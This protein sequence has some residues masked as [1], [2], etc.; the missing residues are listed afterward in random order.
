MKVMQQNEKQ[1]YHPLDY[2]SCVQHITKAYEENFYISF[3]EKCVSSI[4][5]NIQDDFIQ[6]GSITYSKLIV[7]HN[8]KKIYWPIQPYRIESDIGVCYDMLMKVKP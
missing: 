6:N 7:I 8:E 2:Q 4:S 5:F 3:D 1:S